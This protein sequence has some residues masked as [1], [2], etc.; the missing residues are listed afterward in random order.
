M[1]PGFVRKRA[2][3]DKY[4]DHFA[5]FQLNAGKGDHMSVTKMA[6]LRICPAVACRIK[7][8]IYDA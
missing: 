2:E 6:K 8:H 7:R 5:A 3:A 4:C 1:R